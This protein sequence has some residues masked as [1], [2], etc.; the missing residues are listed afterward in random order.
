MS[1]ATVV[2]TADGH[3]CGVHSWTEGYRPLATP[4]K[5]RPSEND[6]LATALWLEKHGRGEEALAYIERFVDL[7]SIQ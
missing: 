3:I 6:I 2:V 4:R 7:P 1:T 5:R